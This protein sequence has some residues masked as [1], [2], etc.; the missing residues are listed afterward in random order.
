MATVDK[1]GQEKLKYQSEIDNLKLSIE[2]PY[3]VLSIEKDV[4]VFRFS[5]S[6]NINPLNCLPNIVYD[7]LNGGNFDY[8]KPGKDNKKCKRCGA[9]FFYDPVLAKASWDSLGDK[10][11]GLLKYTHLAKGTLSPFDG[12]VSKPDEFSHF[13]FYENENPDDNYLRKKFELLD[14]L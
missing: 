1:R 7:R 6:P 3:E 11:R 10:I 13:G 5:H 2:C 12:V 4:D 8:S 14:P 9:S